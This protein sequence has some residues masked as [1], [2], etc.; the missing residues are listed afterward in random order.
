MDF[1]TQDKFE[2]Y[3][4]TIDDKLETSRAQGLPMAQIPLSGIL[5]AVDDYMITH[6]IAH[7]DRLGYEGLVQDDWLGKILLLRPRG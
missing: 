7:Y 1:K 6:I 2:K 3:I 5:E 4:R